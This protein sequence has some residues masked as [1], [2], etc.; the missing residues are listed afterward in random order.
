MSCDTM[1]RFRFETKSTPKASSMRENYLSPHI[2]LPGTLSIRCGTTNT[3][4]S[5]SWMILWIVKYRRSGGPQGSPTH[6]CELGPGSEPGS[7]IILRLWLEPNSTQ[8]L[9]QMGKLFKSSGSLSIR[10]GKYNMSQQLCQHKM[11]FLQWYM[12]LRGCVF[13]FQS[14]I[15]KIFLVLV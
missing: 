13:T 10:C 8:K 6:N 11:W 2:Q 3:S 5:R 1:L 9:A 14:F 7:D 12:I 15:K 4:I